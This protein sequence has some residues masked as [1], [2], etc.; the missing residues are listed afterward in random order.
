M[1]YAAIKYDVKP[2]HEKEITEL[3]SN[4]RRADSPIFRD[5]EGNEVGRLLGTAVF[6]LDGM[7]VRFIHYEGEISDVGRHMSHQRGVHLIEEQLQPYLAQRRDTTT[8]EGFQEHFA[9]SLLTCISQLTVPA[10]A[11]GPHGPQERKAS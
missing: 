1:P 9:N 6:L 2:G 10:A 3:F 7:V 8:P 11:F 5:E 4:F